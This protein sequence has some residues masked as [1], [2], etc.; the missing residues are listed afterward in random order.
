VGFK[1]QVFKEQR[2]HRAFEADMHLAD[3]ALGDG[4]DPHTYEGQALE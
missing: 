1:C 3:I 2:V 4:H